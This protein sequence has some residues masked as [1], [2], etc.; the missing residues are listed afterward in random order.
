MAT[1]AFRDVVLTVEAQTAGEEGIRKLADQIRALAKTGGD[2]AP[3]FEALAA[4]VE[5]L[6]S[7]QAAIEKVKTLASAVEQAAAQQRNYLTIANA[8]A[9]AFV[10][11]GTAAEQLASKQREATTAVEDAREKLSKARYDLN[12][13]RDDA[14]DAAK[15]T[16]GYGTQLRAFKVAVDDARRS[17]DEAEAGQRQANAAAKEAA[18]SQREL[19]AEYA[20]A[21][22][23][24][25][26]TSAALAQHNRELDQ[27]RVT[28]ERLGV[29]TIEL[30]AEEQR[31]Q[32]ALLLVATTAESA[33]V[34]ARELAEAQLAAAQAAE[35]ARIVAEGIAKVQ[36]EAYARD[37]TV[38]LREEAEA[39]KQLAAAEQERMQL[40]QDLLALRRAFAADSTTAA[41]RAEAAAVRERNE[42]EAFTAQVEETNL[43]LRRQM[44]A[45]TEQDVRALQEHIAKLEQLAA[46]ARDVANVLPQAFSQAGVRSIKEIATEITQTE[47]AL[48]L[49]RQGYEAGAI[50]AA[51][52]ARATS[53][54]QA[55][56]QA[57]NSELRNVDAPIGT[58]QRMNA[59]VMGLVT[60]YGALSAAVATVGY[61]AKPV[62]DVVV[63]L[64]SMR[65]ILTQVYG[66]VEEANRQI[67]F[68]ETVANRA[69]LGVVEVSR[70]FVSF[71]TSAHTAGISSDVVANV[72]ERVTNAAGNMGIGTERTNLILLALSQMA[73]KG[74]VSMEELRK[75]LGESLPGA[76]ALMAKGLNI[77]IPQLTKMVEAGDL[78][79][80]HAL[81][82][83]AD[84]LVS[85]GAPGGKVES[86]Q[87]AMARLGNAV[88]EVERKLADSGAWKALGDTAEWIAGHFNGVATSLK[89][90]GETYVAVKVASWISNWASLRSEVNAAK[91]GLDST[92][93]ATLRLSEVTVANTTATGANTI[94]HNEA[95]AALGRHATAADGL[96]ISQ[97]GV[98]RSAPAAGAAVA[99]MGQAVA[100]AGAPV[101]QAAEKVGLVAGA[102]GV[103]RGAGAGLFSLMGGWTG[104][105]IAFAFSFTDLGKAI[106]EG[107]AKWMGWG[108][109][110]DE[111]AKKIAEADQRLKEQRES[112]ARV[113]ESWVQLTAQYREQTATLKKTIEA[114]GEHV[115]AAKRQ[116]EAIKTIADL[117]GDQAAKIRAA[118]EA[119]VLEVKAA[120]QDAKAKEQLADATSRLIVN[121]I[122]QGQVHGG[123]S[124]AEKKRLEQLKEQLK[125]E[126]GAAESAEALAAKYRA[127]AVAA[128]EAAFKAQDNSSRVKELK[129]AYESAQSAV[130]QMAIAYA[131][132]D[133]SLERLNATKEHAAIAE[134][135]YKDSLNDTNAALDRQ[136]QRIGWAADKQSGAL[137]VR[138]AYWKAAEQTAKA[139]G[140]EHGALEA[141][142]NARDLEEQRMRVAIQSKID[143][144]DALARE[145][146]QLRDEASLLS[147]DAYN[148]KMQDIAAREAQIQKMRDEAAASKEVVRG[149]DAETDAIRRK[150]AAIQTV[151]GIGGI[152]GSNT[153]RANGVTY[154]ASGNPVSGPGGTTYG[155]GETPVFGSDGKAIPGVVN[156]AGNT[157]AVDNSYIFQLW[158]RYQQGE[159]FSAN[160]RPAIE[161]ALKAAQANTSLSRTSPGAVSLAGQRDMEAWVIRLQ[162]ILEHT[163]YPQAVSPSSTTVNTQQPSAT[164]A[165][166]RTITLKFGN[167]TGTFNMASEADAAGLENF[168]S[169]MQSSASRA[170][171]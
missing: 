129:A 113:G 15:K 116:A 58:L 120:E 54:A 151:A 61:A 73:N 14:S 169:G 65:R 28:A 161:A 102:L 103:L 134:G 168:L 94:A 106:G 89:I 20:G 48:A 115:T 126:Q 160:E 55:R 158:Q 76:M 79:T 98:T 25:T 146:D 56:L 149:Y 70:A 101:A 80:E 36:A 59:V 17:L 163:Q 86:V 135:R 159:T 164:T 166:S 131:R 100:T 67:A 35:R 12:K 37:L 165:V 114:T 81:G 154:D 57:L 34:Q 92:T 130:V 82:P 43:A 50:G 127:T 128:E 96:A 125:V 147:G 39:Q 60:Q 41:V 84:A 53:S 104:L 156:K 62:Y 6:A 7:Q 108:K 141:N 137:A 140:D 152:G 77:T 33:A 68:V 117:S 145:V 72:F 74:T 119:A 87:A 51:E 4:E 21:S 32:G 5:R 42:A 110:A 47:R 136:I 122:W 132:G 138:E 38:K 88:V 121:L 11:Q 118:A 66:S 75:Q 93:G 99:Q 16:E 29:Q 18:G 2:A 109:V 124:D 69:G 3:Q 153:T 112:Q 52:L 85:L 8:V 49:L 31:L 95:A 105:L 44:L 142:I 91:L 155:S 22:R 133:A 139:L 144:A 9:G 171:P 26:S 97:A 167:T 40:G 46:A 170:G 111:N 107:A 83:L 143:Q 27:A 162:Q 19:A 78:L 24:L 64:E 23:A 123:L 63:Q 90:L 10:E 30:A 157:G 150:A 45:A 1:S 71:A 148:S 13:W